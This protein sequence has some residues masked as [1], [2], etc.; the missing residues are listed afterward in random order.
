M[1][2]LPDVEGFKKYL[3]STALHQ[4]ITATE[5]TDERFIK[6]TSRQKLQRNLKG[7]ELD[8][9]T[10]HGKWLFVHL[11]SGGY[12]VLHFGMTG[13]LVY[14][15]DQGGLHAHARLVLHLANDREL[16]VVSQ[17]MIGRASYADDVDEVLRQ[18]EVGPDAMEI[19]RDD[20]VETLKGRRGAIKSALM[21]QSV[22][23]GIGNVY[24]DEILFQS[25]LHP[26]TK[27]KSLSDKQL[28]DIHRTMRR[29][30]TVASRKGGDGRKAPRTWLL[31]DRRK[32]D[33]PRCGTKLKS[34][35]INGR[36][37]WFCPHCQ[38]KG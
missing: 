30:L 36:T 19:S 11:S 2:E 17:R 37:A 23:A 12:L 27:V 8:S 25:G 10:R 9:S 35:T 4:K 28:K 13:Q 22:V 34:A 16:D 32:T 18:H 24:S 5:V 14:G 26:A 3:D 31:G 7:A 20:F 29:V 1:P 21:N 38:S 33:C 15:K 6:D